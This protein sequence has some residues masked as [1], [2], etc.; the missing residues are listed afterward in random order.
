MQKELLTS[1]SINPCYPFYPCN[2]WPVSVLFNMMR[3]PLSAIALLSATLPARAGPYAPAA[4]QP[5]STALHRSDPRFTAWA[6]AVSSY[7]VGTDCLPQ[8]QDTRRALGPAGDDPAHITCLGAGGSITLTFPVYIKDGP[9]ADFAVF[10]N[11]FLDDYIEHAWVEVSRDGLNFIRFPNHSLTTSP[12]G[13]F[14]LMD[15]TNITGLGCK[16]RQPFGEPYDLAAVG[17]DQVSHVRLV[18]V[19]GNGTARDSANRIIYDPFPNAQSAGLDLD[20]IGVIHSAVWQTLTV[21]SL[22]PDEVNATAFAHLPD[23]RFVLG[24][25]GRL[26]QQTTWGLAGR[27]SIGN[28]GVEFDPAFLAV[29]DSTAILLGA[30]GGFGGSSGVHLL[31]PLTAPAAAPLAVLQNFSAA[32]WPSAITARSGWLIA[33]TNG[34][35]GKNNITWLSTDGSRSGPLTAELSTFSSGI[36]VDAAGNVFASLYELSGPDADKVLRFSATQVDAAA[37]AILA[38]PPAPLAKAAGTP[39]FQFDSASS[40][41]VDAMGRIWASGFKVNHLQVY[42]PATGASR[43]II[44]DHALLPGVNDL[45]YQ[46]QTF[47]R[48]GESYVAFLASDEAGTAGTPLVHGIAPLSHLPVPETLASWRAFQFGAANLTPSNEA[49]LWGNTA[50]PDHDGLSNLLEYA[51]TTPPLTANPTPVTAG[52]TNGRMTVSFPLN[53]L[54]PD[55]TYSVEASSSLAAGSWASIA[56]IPAPGTTPSGQLIPTTVSDTLPITAQAK[57]FLRLRVTVLP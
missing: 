17:L 28:G 23:G 11:S 10:E 5:G 7:Q 34:P 46:V 55:L 32:W 15:P 25:Q 22:L 42:D 14:D 30:G 2:P 26:S 4:G 21:G 37:A 49:L 52:E 53:P 54:R 3:F 41:A 20:A 43:R 16:Y 29:R 50:D 12:V 33:G 13:S 45:L 39:V 27:S 19:I 35:T 24:A 38:G 47:N 8:W 48:A 36:A 18:D 40:L 31:N 6:G 51:L 9:G 57:R 44:P 1:S 56:T